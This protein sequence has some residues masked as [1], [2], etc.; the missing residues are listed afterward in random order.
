[1]QN[2]IKSHTSSF[3]SLLNLPQTKCLYLPEKRENVE[4]ETKMESA[5]YQHRER[6]AERYDGKLT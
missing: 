1:M 6:A 4:T 2:I 3:N 5:A